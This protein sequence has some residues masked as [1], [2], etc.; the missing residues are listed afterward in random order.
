[1]KN[2]QGHKELERKHDGED[3]NPPEPGPTISIEQFTELLNQ[4][5]LT[6][7][8]CCQAHVST[9]VIAAEEEEEFK[10][11]ARRVWEA[12]GSRFTSVWFLLD[13]IEPT[14]NISHVEYLQ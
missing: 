3:A 7:N 6:G 8:I 2:Q 1:M 5:A 10:I 11:L 14:A 9:H 4:Q 12:T 13:A